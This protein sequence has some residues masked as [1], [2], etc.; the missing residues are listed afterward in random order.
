MNDLTWTVDEGDDLW[1]HDGRGGIA[2]AS[3]DA[4]EHHPD[5]G[6]AYDALVRCVRDA[7]LLPAALDVIKRARFLA[8][9]HEA[10]VPT[11]VDL[12]NLLTGDTAGAVLD[13]TERT[14]ADRKRQDLTALRDD[15]ANAMCRHALIG[16]WFEKA[17]LIIADLIAPTEDRQP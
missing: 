15:L 14:E 9:Q 10:G 1:W 5:T 4:V 3:V 12:L 8:R 17:D 7:G 13:R 16:D 2:A 11:L 6:A